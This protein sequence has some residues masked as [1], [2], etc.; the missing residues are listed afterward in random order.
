MTVITRAKKR[1]VSEAK[2]GLLSAALL[3]GFII[4]LSTFW[5]FCYY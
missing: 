5:L 4:D 3:G 2:F 1:E